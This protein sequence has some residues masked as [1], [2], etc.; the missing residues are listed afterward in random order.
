MAG[1]APP[2]C[3]AQ[4]APAKKTLKFVLDC[5]DPVGEGVVVASSFVRAPRACAGV[6]RAA[7]RATRRAAARATPRLSPVA[8]PVDR[9]STCART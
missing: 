4:K 5:T 2:A 1:R 3:P 9:R 7:G 6:R 8:R